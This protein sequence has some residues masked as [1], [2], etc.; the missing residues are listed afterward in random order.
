MRR[1]RAGRLPDERG[2]PKPLELSSIVPIVIL[3][4]VGIFILEVGQKV[5]RQSLDKW[6]FPDRWRPG[7]V[8]RRDA[9]EAEDEPKRSLLRAR[10]AIVY[11]CLFSVFVVV[12]E[13]YTREL[14]SPGTHILVI[15]MLCLACFEY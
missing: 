11:S 1:P 4:W 3:V 6:R 2:V 9:L 15:V 5:F 10:G 12:H 7:R 14:I 8:R 13:A